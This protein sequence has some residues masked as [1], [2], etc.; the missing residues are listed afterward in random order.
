[1]KEKDELITL[2]SKMLEISLVK[3]NKTA[4]V[5][6]NVYKNSD[7]KEKIEKLICEYYFIK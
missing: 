5:L 3:N 1:M 6:F 2:L 7:D 4:E